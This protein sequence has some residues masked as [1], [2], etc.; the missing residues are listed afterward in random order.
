MCRAREPRWG[1]EVGDVSVAGDD[2]R[3]GVRCVEVGPSTRETV[4]RI[5]TVLLGRSNCSCLM[6]VLRGGRSRPLAVNFLFGRAALVV[7]MALLVAP[8]VMLV[9]AQAAGARLSAGS[10]LSVGRAWGCWTVFRSK[11]PVRDPA[12][13]GGGVAGMGAPAEMAT[14]TAS[15][16]VSRRDASRAPGS[17]A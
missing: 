8:L 1:T 12:T 3:T 14:R 5:A 15:A 13:Y 6:V 17:Q 7:V 9:V 4:T 2:L 11:R 16:G 10:R